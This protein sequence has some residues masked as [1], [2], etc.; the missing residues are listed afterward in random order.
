MVSIIAS[1]I[2]CVIGVIVFLFYLYERLREDHT[3]EDIFSSG[4]YLIAGGAVGVVLGVLLRDYLPATVVFIPGGLWFWTGIFGVF[5][6]FIVAQKKF[7]M[8]IY[9]LFES[10][11]IAMFLGV[12]PVLSIKLIFE[13]KIEYILSIFAV[14]VVLGVFWFVNS[15]YK[16]YSWYY[17]GRVGIAGLAGLLAFFVIRVI[18]GIIFWKSMLSLARAKSFLFLLGRI[19]IFVSLTLA[20]FLCLCIYNLSKSKK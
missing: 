10:A 11:L 1:I 13:Q 15:T 18:Y 19:D 14:V 3:S 7:S 4:F 16:R 20:F 8:R 6:L 2:A 9:E 12:M 5:L 17:S